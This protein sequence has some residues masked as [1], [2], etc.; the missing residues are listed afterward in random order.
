MSDEYLTRRTFLQCTGLGTMA[1]M[2][3]CG[4]GLEGDWKMVERIDCSRDR[5]YW[6]DAK[7]FPRT[8][9]HPI[10]YTS[11]EIERARERVVTYDWAKEYR[12]ELVSSLDRR[13]AL[14]MSDEEIR[15]QIS[16]QVNFPLPRCPVDRGKRGWRDHF[17]DWSPEDPEHV[18]CKVCGSVFPGPE[19]EAVGEFEVIGPAGKAVR[20]RYWEDDEGLRYSFGNMLLGYTQQRVVGLA[21]PLAVAYALTGEKGYAHKAAVILAR[22]AEVYPNY[23]VHG[24]GTYYGHADRVG[25]FEHSFYK[26]PPFPFVS[27]RLGNYHMSPF[28]DAGRAY[29]LAQVYD[30][31]SDSGEIEQ[32]SEQIGQDVRTAIERDLL[33]EAIRHTLEVP[34][35]ATN[36][37]GGRI[38]GLGLVGRVLDEPEFVQHAYDLYRILIDN[39]YGYDGYWAEDT[40]NYFSMITGGILRVPDVLS[41]VGGMDVYGEM[42]F[43]PQMYTIPVGLF[44]PDGRTMMANDT[45]AKATLPGH[46]SSGIMSM[47][48]FV[49][50]ADEMTGQSNIPV[51]EVEYALFRR[52][53]VGER[54]VTEEDLLA[55]IPEN[56]LVPGAGNVI[57]GVG[58]SREAVRA[59]LCYGPWGGHHHYDTLSMGLDVFGQE[60]LSDIGYTHTKYRE[61]ATSAGSH[62]TVIVDGRE[63]TKT[64]GKLVTYRPASAKESGFIC[65]EAPGAF[66]DTTVYRRSVLLVPTGEDTGY[67][68]DVFEVEGG[69]VH[70]YLLHGSA[71]FNQRLSVDPEMKAADGEMGESGSGKALYGYLKQTRAADVQGDFGVHFAGEGTQVD[72]RFVGNGSA[73][74]LT[75]EGPSIRR[76]QEDDGKLDEFKYPVVCLRKTGGKSQFVSVIEAHRGEAV[77]Q[78]VE[79]LTSEGAGVALRIV[80]RDGVRVIGINGSGEGVSAALPDGRFVELSGRAGVVTE[81]GNGL[82]MEVL[83]G[84]ALRVG[85]EIL[86]QVRMYAGSVTGLAGDLTGEPS[87]CELVVDVRLPEDGSLDGK[88]MYVTHPSG[89]ETVYRV[90]QVGVEGEGS[91]VFLA[92][93]PR[94]IRGAGKV[95]DGGL[96]QFQS[97]VEHP[98]GPAYPGCRVRVGDH[99][100][101]IRE[102]DGREGFRVEEE[103]NFE[104]LVGE[105]FV[106][107]STGEGDKFRIGM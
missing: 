91:R 76:A 74:L 11:A 10:F 75:S 102:V 1:I 77:V 43:L 21:N 34:H 60:L 40:V 78:E 31:I 8:V 13:K 30:L 101:T 4:P 7:P 46:R 85:H 93:F 104:T 88:V 73:R 96:S 61:W 39:C 59:T 56:Y 29:S 26:D 35:R 65:A 54:R 55:L 58:R 64:G 71:D 45:W 41:G 99:V 68:I 24:L 19:H 95:K 67:V 47:G 42:P 69:E 87:R 98:K 80:E 51:S 49:E 106:V 103:F 32:L 100:F 9:A 107:F 84:S 97:D 63:Q 82:Q 53:T 27:A 90:G 23:P 83:D 92:D 16:E 15:S 86:E 94:F 105:G 57:L 79:V 6:E 66:D 81:I 48:R 5:R 28:S 72:V 36:Y 33:Y 62:N 52:S 17:W 2:A 14:E 20:Y 70:D 44:M 18:R 37:D 25:H 3:G 38:M 12:D 50:A 22:L 89:V